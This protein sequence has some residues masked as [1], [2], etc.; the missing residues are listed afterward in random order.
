MV[1]YAKTGGLADVM[2]ALPR[3]LAARGHDVRVFM[4]WYDRVAAAVPQVDVVLEALDVKVGPY[5]F[6]TRIVRDRANPIAWFVQCAALFERGYIYGGQGDEHRRFLVLSQAALMT[7]QRTAYAPDIIQ[8]NDWQSAMIPLMLRSQFAWDTLFA[9]SKT[10]LTIHNLN[11]QG[12]FDA[13][14]LPEL[15]LGGREHLLH[16]EYLKN[17][18]INFL[19]HG[20][21]YADV[22]T[23]VSPTYAREI[24]TEEHGSGMDPFL[25]AR[26]SSI[27]GILNGV[28]Y[29]E[30]SPEIDPHIAQRYDAANPGLKEINKQALLQQM[31]LPY[32]PGV[33]LAGIVSRLVSQKGFELV[34]EALPKILAGRELQLVVLG[35]G[36]PRLEEMFHGL[37]RSFPRQVSFYR[38]FSN[39][40]AHRIEAGADMFLMPSRYEPCGL[41]QMYSLRYGTVPVVHAT[42]GLADTV[43]LWNPRTQS[44]TGVVFDHHDAAGLAWALNATMR[45][46]RDRS[47][48]RRLMH[49][50]MTR[51]YSWARQAAIYE[52]L[53]ERMRD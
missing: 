20:V 29:N 16:Q 44:G 38:G 15:N 53:F 7:C 41:N 31:G 39:P 25:R 21:I 42:G 4:P 12:G 50:G 1:P 19:L 46:Y 47:A 14:I 3:Y 13:V 48:W 8:C 32:V 10:V 5:E 23:T 6:R 26:K 36:E 22:I 18:R 24:Q 45:I 27:V 33:P 34:G 52:Q 40:L 35:S 43:E 9:E 11:Y 30:W 17:G 51:D 37:Q 2:G 49:N 28:D